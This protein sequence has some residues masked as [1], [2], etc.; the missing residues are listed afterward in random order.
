MD[1]DFESDDLQE[2]LALIRASRRQ[3]IEQLSDEIGVAQR[4]P[5]LIDP[6]RLS[7]L[8]GELQWITSLMRRMESMQE[9]VAQSDRREGVLLLFQQ[10]HS[11]QHERKG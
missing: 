10:L 4:D 7:I 3:L 6:E 11:T 9:A 2:N 8:V 5:R 1:L